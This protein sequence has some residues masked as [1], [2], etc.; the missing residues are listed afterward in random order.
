MNVVTHVPSFVLSCFTDYANCT[1][2][3]D[4][5][6]TKVKDIGYIPSYTRTDLT[7]ALHKFAGFRTDYE[8]TREKAMKGIIRKSKIRY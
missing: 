5:R 3:R 6:M 2:L 7:D 1:T 4:M 8:I